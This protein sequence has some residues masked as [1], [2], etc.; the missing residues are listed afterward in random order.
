[1]IREI[2]WELEILSAEA[3]NFVVS[4]TQLM[5]EPQSIKAK[6]LASICD[7]ESADDVGSGSDL[8]EE[9]SRYLHEK[10]LKSNDDPL[11]WWK[12]NEDV[13]PPLSQLARMFSLLGNIQIFA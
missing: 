3:D 5:V 2:S 10:T 11:L 8:K 7:D 12:K 1:M 13:Y 9:I 4:E 6:F